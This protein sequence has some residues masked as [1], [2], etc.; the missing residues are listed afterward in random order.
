MYLQV[1]IFSRFIQTKTQFIH[2]VSVCMSNRGEDGERDL[3][4]RK[5]GNE[6]ICIYTIFLTLYKNRFYTLVFV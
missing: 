4:E 6:N 3:G 1:T 5:E 2:F